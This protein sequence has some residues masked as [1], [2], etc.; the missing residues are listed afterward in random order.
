VAFLGNNEPTSTKNHR[1][2]QGIVKDDLQ[3]NN[4]LLKLNA[5]LLGVLVA[6]AVGAVFFFT[7]P[8]VVPFALAFFA[9][10][11]SEPAIRLMLR[12]KIPRWLGAFVLMGGLFL[13]IETTVSIVAGAAD[14]FEHRVPVY[15][16]TLQNFVDDIPFPGGVM[17]QVRVDDPEFWMG[18]L[19]INA[20]VG[21]VG[22]WA[23][24]V[25]TFVANTGLVLLMM[26]ALIIG[27][28]TFDER[29]DQAAGDATGAGE[30]AAKVLDAI[31]LGIQRY[32]MLKT[33]LSV[34][35]GLSFW[36]VLTLL[37][38]D[39]AVLWGVL[40]FML[41]FI[42]TVGPVLATVP[43][44]VMIL[45]QYGTEP[46]YALM[47]ILGMAFI[48]FAFGNLLEPKVFG[49]SLNLNFLAVIFALVLWSFLWGLAGAVL[50]VPIMMA[51]SIVCREVPYL[52]PIHDLLRS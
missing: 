40:A 11:A 24:A 21:S 22:S 28:Q 4:Q 9:A 34:A 37:G 49:D 50:S 3:S 13:A 43:T 36:L 14:Q 48:P 19:P 15:L 20:L 42:P 6:L 1:F 26:V 39:F 16:A 27:R 52:R 51:I 35:M 29:L 12:V 33:V 41:N 17:A 7:R 25:T 44:V 31:D 47:A 10:Y 32:M 8:V 30:R 23:G 2:I 38:V 5:A 46:G 45:L 18:V